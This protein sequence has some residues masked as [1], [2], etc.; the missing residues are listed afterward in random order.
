ML[1]MEEFNTGPKCAY[2]WVSYLI[3][4]APLPLLA[5]IGLESYGIDY[6]A[7]YLAGKAVAHGLDP[8]INYVTLSSQFYGPVNAEL[9][10]YSGWKY[11]PLAAYLFVPFGLLPYEIS[12]S[13]FIFISLALFAGVLITALHLLKRSITPEAIIIALIGFP[14]LSTVER[15]QVE[16]A[17]VALATVAVALA[18]RGRTGWGMALLGVLASVKIY[19]LLLAAILCRFKRS[20]QLR[21]LVVLVLV[22]FSIAIMTMLIVP[23][24]WRQSFYTRLSIDFD[25]VPGQVL[26]ALPADS[27]V[28]QGSTTV[29][30]VDARNL[31]HSHDFVFGFG[32]PLLTRQPKTAAAFGSFGII[33]SLYLNRKQS[34]SQQALCLMPWIN[35]A[36][37]LSWIM[38]VVWY[39]PLFL[40]SYNKVGFVPRFILCLPLILPPFLNVSAYFAASLTLIVAKW[41]RLSQPPS[42]TTPLVR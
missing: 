18:A 6:R 10:F 22:L 19:P 2:P 20:L 39:L 15:G 25:R 21:G 37:P 8:Y 26:A 14:V 3:C 13:L 17:L 33:A 30:S 9:A 42:P 27:G 31:I 16:I 4:L 36:N 34:P 23:A 29:R 41:Y 12:K 24:D 28:I 38:G 11:P 7:F 1:V 32:N 40:Y 5:Y 35:I